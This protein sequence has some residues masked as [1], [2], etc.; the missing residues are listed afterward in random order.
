MSEILKRTEELLKEYDFKL[1]EI[2]G[3]LED[4]SIVITIN[5]GYF[6]IA[7]QLEKGEDSEF[8]TLQIWIQTEDEQEL[9]QNTIW[10]LNLDVLEQEIIELSDVYSEKMIAI[11]KLN[12]LI[13]S[14]NEIDLPID[15]IKDYIDENYVGDE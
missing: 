7:L 5:K 11:K 3:S 8:D 9:Y 10:E 4:E 12:K 2:T 15:F 13:T 1:Y 14:L 6:N